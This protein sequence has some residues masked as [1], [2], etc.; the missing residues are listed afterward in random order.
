MMQESDAASAAPTQE[1]A[2][3]GRDLSATIRAFRKN[4]LLF[5]FIGGAIYLGVYVAAES[6]VGR[7]TRRNRFYLVNTA[8]VDRYDTVI[9]GS[10]HAAAL[11]YEDMRVAWS[12]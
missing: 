7:Q 8:P 11:G 3:G 1:S 2:V 5:F 10:S 6:L 9:L 4:A 12:R